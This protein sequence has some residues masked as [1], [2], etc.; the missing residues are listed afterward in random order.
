MAQTLVPAVRPTKRYRDRRRRHPRFVCGPNTF[1]LISA[2]PDTPLELAG[3]HNL[4]QSGA[5]LVFHRSLAIGRF[6]MLNLFNAQ[7]NFAARVTFR[8]IHCAESKDGI[9]TVGGAFT[10]ELSAEEVQ[11]LR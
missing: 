5:G 6:V 1:G 4:S 2:S 7:R 8:V 10:Q 3:V 9:Y 11:W